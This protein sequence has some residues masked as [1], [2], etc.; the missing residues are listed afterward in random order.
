[1]I[2]TDV[3]IRGGGY[4]AQLR[5]DLGGNCYRLC[6]EATRAEILH[7]PADENEL[8]RSRFLFGNPI[9]FQPNRISGGEFVFE[10][11]EYR[12][13]INE[14]ATG[15]HLHGDLHKSKFSV[16]ELSESEVCFEYSAEAGEYI[17]WPHAFT[18]RRR[19]K[20]GEDGLYEWVQITNRSDMPMPFMLAFHTTFN[21]PF[22]PGSKTEDC[23]FE[24]GVVCEHMR[25]E[26]YLPTLEY[27][28]GRER[29]LAIRKGSYNVASGA[30]SAF[31]KNDTVASVVTDKRTGAAIVYEADREYGYRMLWAKDGGRFI[32]VEPQTAAIDC[33][34]IDMPPE[35]CGLIVIPS[36]ASRTLKTR[37]YLRMGI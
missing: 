34:H 14:P 15:C 36:G 11:R 37:I 10:G 5:S 33:F 13:P 4:L 26:K 22:M 19:Y 3:T 28:E 16:A 35:E 2:N 9:L 25:N 31:Y 24:S 18:V 6:H 29:D 12:L 7:S 17:G 32:V 8:L 30:L 21:A 20:I 1:M 27:A 23:Y